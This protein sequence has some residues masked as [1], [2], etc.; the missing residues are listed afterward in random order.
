[1]VITPSAA[2]ANATA[3]LWL[4]TLQTGASAAA[5]E[6]YTGAKPVNTG[7]APDGTTQKLL[8]T[9]SCSTTPDVGTVTNNRL[10]FSPITQDAAADTSGTATWARILDGAGTAV[11]DIDVSDLGG[12]AAMKLNTTAIVVGGPISIASA[13]IDF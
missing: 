5:F 2:L 9:C 11:I 4:T 12:N 3:N 1:M 6:I 7:V 8:G 13:Y 10:T